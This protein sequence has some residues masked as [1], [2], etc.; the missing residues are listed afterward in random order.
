MSIF[1]VILLLLCLAMEISLSYEIFRDGNEIPTS[2]YYQKISRL[3][4]EIEHL[5]E[6]KKKL[7]IEAGYFDKIQVIE[8]QIKAKK[9]EIK[10]VK[11][12]IRI[13]DDSNKY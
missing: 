3:Q 7:K 1:G 11:L 10:R 6:K 4:K 13:E 2:L 9:K 5:T 12:H 8:K